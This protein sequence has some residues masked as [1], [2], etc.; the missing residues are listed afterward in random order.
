MTVACG[1]RPA[2]GLIEAI[3][4]QCAGLRSEPPTSLPS[5]SGDMPEASADPSP[6]LEPPAVT[7][8]SHGLRVSP[9][10]EESVW[11][12][13]PRSGRFVR[14][15]GIAPAAR[16]RSTWGASIG[17]TASA[18]AGTPEV[19]GVPARSMFS[20][21]VTGTPW[22][23]PSRRRPVRRVRGRARLVGE[24]DRDR[25]EV[26]VDRL[27]ALQVGVDD[28]ARGNLAGRDQLGQL[29][30]AAAPQ[31]LRHSSRS[32]RG[33]PHASG[34]GPPRR[35]TARRARSPSTHRPAF[36]WRR[37]IPTS[38][39]PAARCTARLAALSVNTREVSL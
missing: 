31:L 37:W 24:H 36:P 33:D 21:T 30:G 1:T 11:I 20:L 16:R 38:S 18:S 6:P 9:R 8:G 5:P 3:P 26:A 17:E 25:V 12:R 29:A 15:I 39:K 7:P 14:P 28:L 13:S 34:V 10:S 4:Q 2:V 19:V 27:D 32:S 22:S 35:A 23:A